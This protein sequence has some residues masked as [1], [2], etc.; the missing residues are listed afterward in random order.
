MGDAV[1]SR[2]SAFWYW[3]RPAYDLTRLFPGDVTAMKLINERILRASIVE[4]EAD[5]VASGA[6]LLR[7]IEETIEGVEGAGQTVGNGTMRCRICGR[8]AYRLWFQN[9]DR[10]LLVPSATA[11]GGVDRIFSDGEFMTVRV[12]KCENCGHIELFHFQNQ[13]AP[14]AWKD[15]EAET[16]SG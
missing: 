5:W 6:E 10:M 8:G 12:L 2:S 9:R 14:P 1:R 15:A 7:R 4:D 11:P 3:D 13:L 16:P